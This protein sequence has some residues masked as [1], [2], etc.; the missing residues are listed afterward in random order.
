MNQGTK[1]RQMVETE[2][3][4][5]PKSR[6]T[7]VKEEV[8]PSP[9]MIVPPP[10]P[11]SQKAPPQDLGRGGAQH[12][13]IQ[14][15][16]KQAAESLGFRAIIEKQI[17]GGLGS[18]DLL[19]ERSEYILAC[20][21]TVATTIDHEVGNVSK[22]LKAGFRQVAVISSD[23]N[24]LRRI[25]AAVESSLGT[26][27]AKQVLFFLPDQLIAHL[28]ALPETTVPKP[29]QP[30]VQ[31]GYKVTTKHIQLAPQ[32]MKAREDAAITAIAEAMK[33]Q[34]KRRR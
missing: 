21:I 32:E 31:R 30:K 10:E 1:L 29:D 28:N 19:L 4:E 11:P 23:E 6:R 15:R 14:Q 26:E 27:T 3:T 20:E 8:P 2:T 25:A 33:K 12:Q 17:L 13:A 9:P 18:I 22:C 34:G 24:R 5:E 7:V 16:L